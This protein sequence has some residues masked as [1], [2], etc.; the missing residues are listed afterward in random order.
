[1]DKML[2]NSPHWIKVVLINIYGYVLARRRFSGSFRKWYNEYKNNLKKPP[3]KIREEQL[4]LLK[5]N[6]I[7][8]FENIPYYKR[9]F[10]EVGLDPY[11]IK[12]VEEIQ[13]IPFLTKEII[14]NEFDNLYNKRIKTT[15][16]KKH[17]T[18]G[19]TGEKL[20]FLVPNELFYKKNTAFL[21]RFYAMWGIKPKDKR[22]TLGGRVFTIT[23]P[24]W[25]FNRFENQLLMS[26]HHLSFQTVE[27]YISRIEKFNPVFMQGHPSAMLL[28]AKYL[29]E[30]NKIA[31]LNLK[32]IFTTG[33]TLV[34]EDQSL[35][36][37]AFQCSVAQQYGSGENCFSAQHAPNNQGYLINYEHG[38]IELVGDEELKEVVVTSFQNE[39]MPFI[40]YKMNDYVSEV[41]PNFSKEFNLPILFDKIVGRID[42]VV[43]LKNGDSV[44][45][46][47]IRMNLKPL[48]AFGT[49]YQ[50]I[51]IDYDRFLL[52]LI[53]E[54]R[55]LKINQICTIL[56]KLFGDDIKIDI[57]FGETLISKG[58]KVRNVISKIQ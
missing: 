50:L 56:K 9:V 51:Q 52:K 8:A 3:E 38:F 53:D 15:T 10:N 21:Y 58:G 2:L 46:V 16:Y 7:Y 24:Y 1:M 30:N 27:S 22:V 54:Q 31:K 11:L 35:I 18:S 19:S 29:L 47:T 26:A 40:R 39:V 20:K 43:K 32:A 28:M 48:L 14:R 55:V 44:L 17:Q 49:N 12:S 4:G 45:P 33:E 5:K 57:H 41:K 42:D 6:L 23:A 37:K 34:N 25:V 13:K 36:E